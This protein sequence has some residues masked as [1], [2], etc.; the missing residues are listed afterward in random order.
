MTKELLE[1]ELRRRLQF[2]NA[3]R[4]NPHVGFSKED[5]EFSRGVVETLQELLEWLKVA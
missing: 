3:L 5:K 1:Q 4:T 2:E